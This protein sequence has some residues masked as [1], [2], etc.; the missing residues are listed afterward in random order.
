[1]AATINT[2]I[3]QTIQQIKDGYNRSQQADN[4]MHL[5]DSLRRL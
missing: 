4:Y 3:R 1:M 5:N 2:Q